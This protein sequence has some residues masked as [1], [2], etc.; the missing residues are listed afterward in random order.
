MSNTILP[1]L[2]RYDQSTP[3]QFIIPPEP[4]AHHKP[5]PLGIY[6]K[7]GVVGKVSY[8]VPQNR[9]ILNISLF[10]KRHDE[11]RRFLISLG[12]QNRER[13]AIFGLLRFYCYYGKAYPK[14]ADIATDEYISKRTFWRAIQKLRAVG[15]IEVINRYL[16][17]RQISNLYRL[18]KL[19]L[20]IARLLAERGQRFND[21]T[22]KLISFFGSFWKEIWEAEINL[23]DL[24]P[25]RL[26]GGR[27]GN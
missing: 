13:D 4:M 10:H 16:N 1:Q 20:M 27:C 26:V 25:I 18:D 11:I 14:A 3:D 6:Y 23:A 9:R 21:F 19:V 17:H 8:G 12:L 7:R 5:T 24:A 2:S 15:A 22:T